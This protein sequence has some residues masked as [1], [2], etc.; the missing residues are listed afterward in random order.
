VPAVVPLLELPLVPLC[1][2]CAKLME[3]M[4]AN[5]NVRVKS[6]FTCPL[7]LGVLEMKPETNIL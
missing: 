5:A 1:P 3:A 6:F 4:K 2:L 7:L